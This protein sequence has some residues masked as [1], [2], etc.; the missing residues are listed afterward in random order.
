[1]DILTKGHPFS[2]KAA[3]NRIST[4]TKMM[5][6][7]Q[8]PTISYLANGNHNC[9]Q[10]IAQA[11]SLEVSP[12]KRRQERREKGEELSRFTTQAERSTELKGMTKFECR[13]SAIKDQQTRE[14]MP[15]SNIIRKYRPFLH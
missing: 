10:P 3:K 12:T 13:A 11:K 1:L 5:T 9:W 15:I 8:K 2:T 7:W 14:S 6:Q 4:Q